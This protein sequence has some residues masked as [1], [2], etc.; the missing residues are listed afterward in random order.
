MASF[1]QWETKGF[2]LIIQ[3]ADN[4][5][6]NWKQ[7]VVS[8]GQNQKEVVVLNAIKDGETDAGIEVIEAENTIAISLSQKQTG[9][10]Q[11]GKCDVQVNV[12]YFDRE[13]DTTIEGVV[14]VRNNLH[15]KVMNG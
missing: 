13:R 10:F 15:K 14:D 4:P 6:E 5:L 3:G 2:N 12:L 9:K 11:K 8:L 1:Y 7:V